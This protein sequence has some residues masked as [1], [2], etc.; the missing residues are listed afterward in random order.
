MNILYE[1]VLFCEAAIHHR[2]ATLTPAPSPCP[3][4]SLSSSPGCR[5]PSLYNLMSLIRL[6]G[7]GRKRGWMD[8]QMEGWK[9]GSDGRKYLFTHTHSLP[10]SLPVIAA[11]ISHTPAL[12]G[13]AGERNT[14][15]AN[16]YHDFCSN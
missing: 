15:Q 9:D 3:S 12:N 7:E 14:A 8:G 13:D 11:L 2:D 1:Y 10:G 5:G 6:Y 16:S 4:P